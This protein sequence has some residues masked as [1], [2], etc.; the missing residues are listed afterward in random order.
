MKLESGQVAV[1]TGAASGI[2]FALA[3]ALGARGLT[4]VLAD[5]DMP[6]RLDRGP[7]DVVQ[8]DG[9]VV[10]I[11]LVFMPKDLLK[12]RF[13]NF[14]FVN[15]IFGGAIPKNYIPAVEKGIVEAAQRGYLAG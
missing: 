7:D 3:E 5:V 12:I 6:K 15:E 9:L 13:G 11:I 2:G 14:E 4:I 1:V 8:G 10:T